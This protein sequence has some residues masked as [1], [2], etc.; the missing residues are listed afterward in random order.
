MKD[1]KQLR[2]IFVSRTFPPTTGGLQQ[3]AFE[4]S[5]A[6][7]QKYP[8]KLI[9]WGGSRYALPVIYPWLL[10]QTIWACW[11]NQGDVVYL[12]DGVLAIT[13]VFIKLL[14][15]KPVAMNMH[16]LDITFSWKLYRWMLRSSVSYVDLIIT[17]SDW[18]EEQIHNLFPDKPI[19]IISHG[20][21]DEFYDSKIKRAARP[22]LLTTGRL[23]ERK[24]VAWFIDNVM[25]QL[26]KQHPSLQYIVIGDGVM[27][28]Q[29]EKLI[30]EHRLSNNVKLLGK[31][32]VAV[33]NRWYNQANLFIM[34][35][36][37][38]PGD[39]EGF[40]DDGH[41]PGNGI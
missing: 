22:T 31:A 8:V 25:P 1:Q 4:L 23:V 13:A 35:N 12:Q 11:R 10:A 7:A 36:I 19:K 37:K 34:P 29:I 33:R 3:A 16:G 38:V 28:P 5:S 30:Q 9:K 24:G 17:A 32:S 21:K 6:L 15:R 40:G 41:R 18:S 2:I 39:A 26:V 20:V 14:S 27:R